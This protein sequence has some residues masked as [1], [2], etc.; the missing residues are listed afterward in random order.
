MDVDTQDELIG[1]IPIQEAVSISKRE[2]VVVDEAHP[3]DLDVYISNYSG[4]T[5]IERLCHIISHSPTLAIDAFHL[6][7]KL[8]QETRDLSLHDNLLMSYERVSSVPGVDLPPAQEVAAVTPAWITD[9]RANN[10]KERS[11]LELELRTYTNNM[12]KESIRMANRDLGHFYR[13]TGDHHSA[14]KHYTK[15]REYCTTSQH[16]L[17]MCL[18]VLELLIEQRNFAHIPTYIY[19]AEAALDAVIASNTS[20]SDKGSASGGVTAAGAAAAPTPSISKKMSLERE[21]VQ[22]KLDLAS[23]LSCLAQSNYEKAAYHLVRV[24]QAKYLEDWLGKVRFVV[25][26][27]TGSLQNLYR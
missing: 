27:A 8:V 4:R 18:S 22:A 6:G 15:S 3:F 12:I 21:R 1:T 17:D 11:K 19:K 14:Y 10:K 25:L 23:G 7:I 13:S 5:A 24:G 16:I 20:A 26:L 2:I 9:T